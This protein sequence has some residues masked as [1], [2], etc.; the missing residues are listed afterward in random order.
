MKQ[1]KKNEGKKQAVIIMNGKAGVGKDTL[2][3]YAKQYYTV[4]NVSSVLRVKEAA[5]VVGWDGEY[6]NRG[7]QFLVDIKQAC[8]K[9]D[10]LLI[11]NFLVQ[12]YNKFKSVEQDIMFVAIREA[13]EIEKFKQAV[14]QARSVWVVRDTG[15]VGN[16]DTSEDTSLAHQYD[17]TFDNSV[18][19]EKACKNFIKLIE[20]IRN[21]PT[22]LPLLQ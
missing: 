18:Q 8:I 13:A 9:Y 22:D 6:D 2:M 5:I 4:R 17:Y 1:I 20:K 10:P 7:R 16:V 15:F 21:T 12:E 3:D 14:P 19:L 11:T